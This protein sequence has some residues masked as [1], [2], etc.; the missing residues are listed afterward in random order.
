MM[1]TGY[2]YT[3]GAWIIADDKKDAN[4]RFLKIAARYKNGEQLKLTA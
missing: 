1:N 2:G 4:A 3:F